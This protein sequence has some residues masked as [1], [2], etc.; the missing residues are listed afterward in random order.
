MSDLQSI[1]NDAYA[2][3]VQMVKRL[4]PDFWERIEEL[5]D[6]EDRTPEDDA[7]LAKL[8]EARE[9]CEDEDEAR[10]AIL[11]DALSVEVRS[12]WHTPGSEAENTEYCILLSTGGPATEYCILLPTGGPAA[13]IV[14][15][16]SQWKQPVSATLQV[17][18]WGA[19]WTDYREADEDTLL[20]YADV[21]YFGE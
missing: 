16:L 8:E 5:R 18:D 13:R 3:L 10:E 21:F 20:K 4:D 7:E 11:E 19:P 15:E 6:M 12:D 14:G 2:S 17:Q 1:G 9:H